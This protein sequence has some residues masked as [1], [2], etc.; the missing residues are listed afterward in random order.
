VAAI[1]PT[2]GTNAGGTAVTITG[3][4][5]L[6]G[7]TVS[8]GGTAAT[9]VTAASSTSIT[10]TAPAHTAGAVSVVV[11]NTDGQKGSLANGYT[12]VAPNPAPT[13]VSIAPSS[14]PTAGSTSVTITGTGFLSGATVSMGG[15][16]ATGV[17]L[18]SSTSITA[19]TPAHAAGAVN[20]VV[21]NT[22][23][24]KGTL[25][26][27][28]TY[29]STPSNLG[30]GVLGGDSSSATVTAG[31]T[32]SYTLSIG[33]DGMGGTASISCAGAPTAA[34][35]SVPASQPFNSTTPATFNVT[36]TT[37]AR[38]AGALVVPGSVGSNFALACFAPVAWL[39]VFA[40]LGIVVLPGAG[41]SKKQSGRRYLRLLPLTLALFL[42][43]C[44]GGAGSSSTASPQPAPSSSGTP[45][46]NYTLSVMATSGATTQT[47]TLT[48]IVK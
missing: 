40:M 36:V 11:T 8:L 34:N 47:T 30:L 41:V 43:S 7:A 13:A 25:A 44:G 38:T 6:T 45:A 33:G 2:S 29:S 23:G 48:L 35:C 14:G 24:Q 16:G 19:I 31:Q 27:G 15:T 12:Y 10:A 21:T 18:A 3:T 4:G 42:V 32:A 37:T 39:S 28:Y 20:V 5:F 22:D 26:N 1:S 9:G 17:T 46:G